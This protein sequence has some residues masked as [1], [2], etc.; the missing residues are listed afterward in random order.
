VLGIG[1]AL[2]AGAVQGLLVVY[3]IRALGL[4]TT[5]PRIGLLFGAGAGGALLSNLLLLMLV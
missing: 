4:S 2:T 3:G 1:N 5:D